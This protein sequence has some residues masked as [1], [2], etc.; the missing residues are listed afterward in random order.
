MKIF[1]I[2][3]FGRTIGNR[4]YDDRISDIITGEGKKNCTEFNLNS[5]AVTTHLTILGEIINR[6]ANNSNYCK[7]VCAG[8][9]AA[10]ITLSES[11]TPMFLI[12][13]CI[14][15]LAIAILD[16]LYVYLKNNLT[17]QQNEFVENVKTGK[18]VNPFKI[19]SSKKGCNQIK[20]IWEGFKSKSV[21]L[22]YVAMIVTLALHFFI[23]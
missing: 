13:W 1:E 7:S 19:D 6:L 23:K 15:I 16:S 12:I 17:R 11:A 3:V 22:F 9:V 20:G 2:G 10:F 8:I 14:P 18:E 4:R 21:W 5:P